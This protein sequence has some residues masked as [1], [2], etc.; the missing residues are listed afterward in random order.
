M[1]NALIRLDALQTDVVSRAY[2]SVPLDA[3]ESLRMCAKYNADGSVG[4]LDFDFV[5]PG[6]KLDQESIP[7]ASDR[8]ELYNLTKAH[9]QL[10]QEL[11][12]SRWFKMIVTIQRSG[13]FSVAF[14]YKDPITEADMIE[15]G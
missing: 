5:L 4:G 1:T 7:N 3:W 13:Q 8:A 11:G 10:A 14:E 12:P 15:R 2:Q 9:W 6:G